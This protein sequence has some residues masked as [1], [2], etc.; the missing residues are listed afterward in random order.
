MYFEI[1]H[2]LFH[3]DTFVNVRESLPHRGGNQE[4]KW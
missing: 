1:V 3:W 2:V 4:T